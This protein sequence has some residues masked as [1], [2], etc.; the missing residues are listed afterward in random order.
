MVLKQ[1]DKS[2]V[3]PDSLTFSYILGNCN[4][5]DDIIKVIK[6]ASFY[7]MFMYNIHALIGDAL[8]SILKNWRNQEFNP[9]N[10]FS[11]HL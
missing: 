7:L 6:F 2:K 3:K 10:T 5:E 8:C 9:Q 1:M 4:S 11:W